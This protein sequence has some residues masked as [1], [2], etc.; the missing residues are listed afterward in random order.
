MVIERCQA[1]SAGFVLPDVSRTMF[2][3]AMAIDTGKPAVAI[4]LTRDA[5]KRYRGLLNADQ[6]RHL[7]RQ[8]ERQLS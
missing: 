8:A 6:C 7:Q 2:Y 3:A 1:V 5:D 4:A